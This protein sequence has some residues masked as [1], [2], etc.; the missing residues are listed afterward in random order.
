MADAT[1][2]DWAWAVLDRIITPNKTEFFGRCRCL[3][4]GDTE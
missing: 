3:V 1:G 4:S 2:P